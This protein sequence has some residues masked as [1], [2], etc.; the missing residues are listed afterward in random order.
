MNTG[1]K[2]CIYEWD[3]DYG[4]YSLVFCGCDF[5]WECPSP[6][7]SYHGKEFIEFCE[8]ITTT[9]IGPTGYCVFVKDPYGGGYQT[10][11]E[12]CAEGYYCGHPLGLESG[13]LLYVPCVATPTTSDPDKGNNY[14]V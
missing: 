5:D 11:E 8:S 14:G 7:H 3:F 1:T 9:T 13:T 12:R 6:P 10:I 2:I 4:K